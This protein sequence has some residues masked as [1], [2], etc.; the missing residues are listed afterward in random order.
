MAN[1]LINSYSFETLQLE[2]AEKNGI[3]GRL[4]K[5]QALTAVLIN[6]G[7]AFSPAM[8]AFEVRS[9]ITNLLELIKLKN[10]A[11]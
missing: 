5:W 3:S 9:V 8:P 4:G 6:C 10:E 2:M 1:K 7:Y 11:Q